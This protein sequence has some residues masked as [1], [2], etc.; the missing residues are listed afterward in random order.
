[1]G[2]KENGK[3]FEDTEKILMQKKWSNEIGKKCYGSGLIALSGRNDEKLTF[4]SMELCKLLHEENHGKIL[5]FSLKYYIQEI[6]QKYPDIP[7]H[8]DDTAGMEMD[9]LYRKVRAISNDV[10]IRLIVIDELPLLLWG[11]E[12]LTRMEEME[13]I[14]TR[15][16]CI[17]EELKIPVLVLLPLSKYTAK[18]YSVLDELRGYGNI[19]SLLKVIA[20]IDEKGSGC[21]VRIIKDESKKMI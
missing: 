11:K 2:R 10:P 1:M 20:Y 8:I 4:Y 7:Y 19:E 15:L 14:T 9:E 5:Y 18:D 13:R 3:V 17:S 16:K 21:H 6:M 12:N